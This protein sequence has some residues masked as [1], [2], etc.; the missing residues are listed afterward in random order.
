MAT[1][2]RKNPTTK[3]IQSEMARA[4]KTSKNALL[5]W[6][7]SCNT[8]NN[9]GHV[10]DQ[11]EIHA[12]YSNRHNWDCENGASKICHT[13]SHLGNDFEYIVV[14]RHLAGGWVAR[15]NQLIAEIECWNEM[16]E[17]SDA[18]CLCPI[19]KYFTSKSDQVKATSK[20]MQHN[21]VIIAQ[22]A[23]YVSNADRACRKAE[24]MNNAA[25]LIGEDANSR[26]KKLQD[27]SNKKN[28]WDAMHNGGNSGVIFDYHKNCYKAVF[29]DYAL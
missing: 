26:Y 4:K 1:T 27:L 29:I 6:E 12:L 2:T 16:A 10:Y 28:W 14:K 22:K 11:T 7:M 24:E 23:V 3:A 8:N 19:L 18:D 20:T 17:T 25:G 15:G 9:R 5:E 21:V 13:K